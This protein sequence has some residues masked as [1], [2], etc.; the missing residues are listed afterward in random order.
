MDEQTRFDYWRKRLADAR[1]AEH[2]REQQASV[3]QHMA[4]RQEPNHTCA[5]CEAD[6]QR[7]A[8]LACEA[9][10]LGAVCD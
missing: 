9:A 7:M 5:N 6:E 4:A 3:R 2:I 8:S 10:H 1:E